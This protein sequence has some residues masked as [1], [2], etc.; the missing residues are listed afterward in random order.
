MNWA[1]RWLQLPPDADETAIK[2]SYAKRLRQHRP[3]TDP[4]GFQQ[5]H[6]AYQAALAWARAR[7]DE[8]ED[9]EDDDA[10]AAPEAATMAAGL[11]ASDGDGDGDGADRRDA[12]PK[13]AVASATDNDFLDTERLPPDT[14]GD[15]ARLLQ[16]QRPM[17]PTPTPPPAQI[18]VA[19]PPPL[20]APD[21]DALCDELLALA[22]RAEPQTLQHWLERQPTLWSLRDK[23]HVGWLLCHRLQ[24]RM[25]P[26]QRD[27]FAI[28]LGFF[29]LDDIA[30]GSAAQTLPMLQERL[31]LAW[32]MQPGNAHALARRVYPAGDKRY[33]VPALMRQL[34]RPFA[35]PQALWTGLMPGRP[36]A[37]RQL[38]LRLDQGRLDTL[39]APLDRQQIG[40]WMRATDAGYLTR[41]RLLVGLARCAAAALLLAIV[42]VLATAASALSPDP[43]P[44]SFALSRSGMAALTIAALWAVWLVVGMLLRWQ[45]E[46]ESA[47]RS[48]APLWLR[49]LF[50]PLLVGIA[51]GL[52]Y[53]AG[54]RIP[55]SIV[56]MLALLLSIVRVWRRRGLE[57]RLSVRSTW[58]TIFVI[59]SLFKGL[60]ALLHSG[61]IGA[62]LALALWSWDLLHQR[63]R[64]RWRRS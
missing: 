8:D 26:I 38:L 25:P 15:N 62:A 33:R 61:E 47:N 23:A 13:P 6:A 9:A 64:L 28:L 17:P 3:D 52:I 50:I 41:A 63:R 30:A 42:V 34:T 40:F 35:L 44:M 20:P 57:Y 39:P 2:R 54:Q 5:L 56:A 43:V 58:W 21:P 37:L 1:L 46:P 14:D 29:G 55:G 32:E 48:P 10:R 4:E 31:H 7:S 16:Q 60:L 59:P 18:D 49:L 51:L 19:Q 22:T 36:R 45:S 11:G 27:S 53:G 24:Q 12:Q